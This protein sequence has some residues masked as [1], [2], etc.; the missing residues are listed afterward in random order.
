MQYNSKPS[1]ISTN[2]LSIL[3]ASNI[4]KSVVHKLWY[5]LSTKK[6]GL[7]YGGTG[8]RDP[9]RVWKDQQMVQRSERPVF[10]S[11]L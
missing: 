3:N 7:S 5:N 9:D 8:I 10:K 11:K 2:H 1:Q 4:K 6:L